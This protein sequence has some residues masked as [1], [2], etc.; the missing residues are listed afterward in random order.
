MIFVSVCTFCDAITCNP[1]GYIYL[2]LSRD[3]G[4]D[5]RNVCIALYDYY[6]AVE[7]YLSSMASN[8]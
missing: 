7:E 3:T 6:E 5:L 4:D 2:V 8:S 1:L